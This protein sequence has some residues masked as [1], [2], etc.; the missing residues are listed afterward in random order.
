MGRQRHADAHGR[1][2]VALLVAGAVAAALLL[3]G[4]RVRRTFA[5]R[6]IPLLPELGSQPSAVGEHLREAFGAAASS[7]SDAAAVG[8][9]C[10][11]LHADMFLAEAQRC[12]AA[13]RGTRAF[14]VEMELLPRPDPERTRRRRRG[15]PG[16]CGCSTGR[17]PDFAPAWWRLGEAEFKRGR[18]GAAAEA[19]TRAAAAP[20]PDRGLDVPAHTADVPVAAYAALGLARVALA[21]GRT[22]DAHRFLTT[23]TMLAPRFGSAYRLLADTN[24]TLGRRTDADMRAGSSGSPAGVCALRRPDGGCSRA[25]LA[26]RD[27]PSQAGVGRRSGNERPL[28]RVSAPAGP[29]VRSRQPGRAGETGTRASQ[30]GPERRGARC[31]PRVPRDGAGRL[32]GHRA[33]RQLPHR[34]R[35]ARGGGAL[36]ARRAHRARRRPDSLQSRRRPVRA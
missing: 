22:A 33:N 23:A 1:G 10:L 24:A 16:R 31:V 20:E 14:S 15:S 9:Y 34:A 12:Y 7:P 28:E 13:G 18:Y 8:S 5:A 2:R 21:E 35:P 25:C 17:A 3:L 6:D 26:Q 19:W 11:A 4:P 32:P 30:P 27:V 36:S 29:D